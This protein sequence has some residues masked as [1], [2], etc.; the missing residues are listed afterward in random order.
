MSAADLGIDERVA[1]LL[2]EMLT[3]AQLDDI[4]PLRPVI[5]D[6]L[7]E[8]SLARINGASGHGKTFVALDMAACVGSGTPWHG[9][10]VQTGEVVYLVAEGAR[11]IRKR[12]RAWE[13]H[14]G[15]PMTG[16]QF[17]PRPVQAVDPEWVVLVEACRRIRP[18]LIVV[19]TQARITVGIEE[20]SNAEMGIVVDHLERATPGHR[21]ERDADPPPRFERRPRP[22]RVVCAWR[23][24]NRA[25]RRPQP[26]RRDRDEHET[27]GRRRSG[28]TAVHD[29]AGQG[30]GR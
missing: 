30:R 14:H 28:A 21:G 8:D 10:D 24:A 15:K 29:A 22:R 18:R 7:F 2:A 6:F 17:L 12:V 11:G 26:R 4:P 9:H 5:D 23:A 1:D 16:V 25:H 13:L 20:S 19:D 3:S 27:E